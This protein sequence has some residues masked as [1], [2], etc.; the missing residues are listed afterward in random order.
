MSLQQERGFN[1]RAYRRLKKKIDQTYPARQ[2]VAIVRGRVVADAPTF[3]ELIAILE[4][5]EKD[6][7]RRFVVQAGVEYP[8]KV[9]IRKDMSP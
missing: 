7:N 6:P 1:E 8:K 5:I 2:Y 4:P 9:I 3:H